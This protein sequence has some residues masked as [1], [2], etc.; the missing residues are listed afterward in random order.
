MNYNCIKQRR[1]FLRLFGEEITYSSSWFWNFIASLHFPPL[2]LVKHHHIIIEKLENS[3][4]TIA[5][6]HF[7]KYFSLSMK[8][9]IRRKELKDRG[10]GLQ[11]FSMHKNEN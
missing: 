2:Q 9:S 4:E 5:W 10:A 11:C 6:A 8:K 1:I 7:T 3:N